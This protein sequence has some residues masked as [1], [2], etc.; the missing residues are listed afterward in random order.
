MKK[1]LAIV[2]FAAVVMAG[3][4]KTEQGDASEKTPEV[5]APVTTTAAEETTE[6]VTVTELET[7][8]VVTETSAAAETTT[9]PDGNVS[10]GG[11]MDMYPAIYQGF[12]QDIFNKTVN[13]HDG[14]ASIEYAFRDLD[15]DGIPE[16]LLKYGTCEA[17]FQIHIYKIDNEGE[18]NDLGLFGGGHTSFA[19]DENTGNFVI[20]WGHMGACSIEYYAWKNGTL[21]HTDTYSFNIDEQTPSYDVV[22]DE[23][24]IRYIEYVTSHQYDKGGEI[25]SYFWHGNGN[26][27]EYD[28]LY[29]D[30]MG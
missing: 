25:K 15:A 8:T 28:G 11:I 10:A 9:E 26:Y 20:V 17:D 6:A 2:C 18:V 1:I 19:Y 14:M 23:K 22:L 7:E 3:C 29:L 4:G 21:E 5:T 16:L 27:E 13:E 30:Y 24:G 12:I